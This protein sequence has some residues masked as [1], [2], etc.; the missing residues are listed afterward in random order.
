VRTFEVFCIWQHNFKFTQF[1]AETVARF[2]AGVPT[3]QVHVF[4]IVG[5]M[6]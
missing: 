2:T 4:A 5:G 1:L 6:V 3:K